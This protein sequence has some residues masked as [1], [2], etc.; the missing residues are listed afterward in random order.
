MPPFTPPPNDNISLGL[1]DLVPTKYKGTDKYLDIV[2]WNIRYFHDMDSQ[3][4]STV[5]RILAALN[6]DIIVLQEIRNNSLD[7][8]AEKLSAAGAGHYEVNYGATGGNQR[9]AIMHDLDWVRSKDDIRELFGKGQITADGKDAFPRLPL[10]GVFTTVSPDAESISQSFDFQLL[11]L[12]LKSQ[13]GGGGNQRRKSAE[14]LRDWLEHDAPAVDADVIMLGDW[15]AS[16]D[17]TAWKPFHELEGANK[18]KFRSLNDDTAISHLM[19]RNKTDIGS[20]LDLGAI[21]MAAFDE[22]HKPPTPVRWK[23]LDKLLASNPKA[24][25]IRKYLKEVR[26]KISDHL[27]VVVRFYIDERSPAE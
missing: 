16:P 7:V 4:V 14:A 1:N 23:S 3:R 18:A 25:Q 2:T 8:V 17:D 22:L 27:P 6:A 9:V 10:L 5:A 24:A 21:S 26:D 12:H 20:R 15:N 19:Y 13:R 11:G